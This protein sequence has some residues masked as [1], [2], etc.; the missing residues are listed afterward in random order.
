MTN[1]VVLVG[2]LSKDVELRYSSSGAAVGRTSIA[3]QR[4]FKD[5]V[6]GK[7]EADFINLVLFGKTAEFAANNTV[8]GNRVAIIGRIQTGSY[9]GQDGKRVYTTD[10]VVEQFSPIDW[11]NSDDQ[12]GQPQPNQGKAY[13][14]QQNTPPNGGYAPNTQYQQVDTDQF[15]NSKGPIEVSEDD[16]PF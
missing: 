16:L 15:A 12:G 13:G 1:N 7:Y 2:R 11:A 5:K 10:T 14:G 6:T 4:Q 9:E 3:V 8:K